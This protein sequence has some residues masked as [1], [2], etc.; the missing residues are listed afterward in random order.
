MPRE[1]QRQPTTAAP[2]PA[3]SPLAVVLEAALRKHPS[4]QFRRWATRLLA[5]DR[6]AAKAKRVRPVSGDKPK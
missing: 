3:V 1:P 4:A 2:A 5:G 6:P